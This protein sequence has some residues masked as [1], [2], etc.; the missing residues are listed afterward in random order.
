LDSD[1]EEENKEEAKAEAETKA[2][3]EERDPEEDSETLWQN[4]QPC[5]IIRPNE[6][7][8]WP[9]SVVWITFVL[10]G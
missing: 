1:D 9:D 4:S 3:E 6:E 10:E 2:G 7:R 8:F 5:L